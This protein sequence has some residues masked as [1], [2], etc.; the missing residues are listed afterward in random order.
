MDLRHQKIVKENLQHIVKS[1]RN[2]E[3]QGMTDLYERFAG[4]LY[5]I[6]LRI[7][8]DEAM[9]NDVLQDTFV[10]IWKN[11]DQ[12]EESR[13]QLFTWMYQIAR[14]AALDCKKSMVKHRAEEIQ[15]AETVVSHNTMVNVDTINITSQLNTLPEKYRSVVDA[16]FFQGYSQREWS[17]KSGLPLGTIKTRLRIALRELRVVYDKGVI[18]FILFILDILC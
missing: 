14:N 11:I 2:H 13:S 12:Y 15:I 1:I 4:P 8:T 18:L 7:V 16:L 9:A 6:I 5:G 10:K 3:P 17:Q